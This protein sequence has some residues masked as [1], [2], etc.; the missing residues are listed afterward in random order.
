MGLVCTW[1]FVT[2]IGGRGWEENIVG[3]GCVCFQ[4]MVGSRSCDPSLG[5][6][7]FLANS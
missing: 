4:K 7:D 5:M 3:L 2:S 1:V 6:G